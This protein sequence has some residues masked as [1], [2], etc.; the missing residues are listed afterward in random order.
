MQVLLLLIIFRKLEISP[1]L[2][3][4]AIEF[5]MTTYLKILLFIFGILQA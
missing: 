1:V 5:L 4:G 3:I 2:L